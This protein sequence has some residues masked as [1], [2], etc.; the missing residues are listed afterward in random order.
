MR[1][2]QTFVVAR[3]LLCF[4]IRQCAETHHTSAL[5]ERVGSNFNLISLG[6][7]GLS[8][9]RSEFVRH[10]DERADFRDWTMIMYAQTY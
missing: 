2:Q 4:R 10:P 6:T 1:V 3:R 8:C 9:G 5:Y 7:T